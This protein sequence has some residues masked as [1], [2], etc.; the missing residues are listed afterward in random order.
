MS[1]SGEEL[2][3]DMFDS[4]FDSR[5]YDTDDFAI[6]KEGE[7]KV[8]A[9]KKKDSILQIANISSSF[10]KIAK[11]LARVYGRCE[12]IPWFVLRV[13]RSPF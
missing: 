4:S 3:F 8:F 2:G 1:G 9:K 6:E 13:K 11:S 12:A 5:L 7:T 10:H